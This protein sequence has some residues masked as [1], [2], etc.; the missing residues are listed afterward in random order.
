MLKRF[1]LLPCVVCCVQLAACTER[2]QVVF[3]EQGHRSKLVGPAIE[4]FDR[5]LRG[6]SLAPELHN[7]PLA[8]RLARYAREDGLEL[9]SVPDPAYRLRRDLVVPTPDGRLLFPG[10][11]ANVSE[12]EHAQFALYSRLLSL[13][14]PTGLGTGLTTPFSAAY[15]TSAPEKLAR[16]WV[17]QDPTLSQA[18]AMKELYVQGG[19]VVYARTTDSSRPPYAIVSHNALYQ[20]A[21]VLRNNHAFSDEELAKAEKSLAEGDAPASSA[22][23]RRIL[24]NEVPVPYVFLPLE[25][26]T[27]EQRTSRYFAELEATRRRLADELGLPIEYVVVVPAAFFHV[28]MFVRPIEPGVVLVASQEGVDAGAY[29]VYVATA[30]EETTRILRD[31]G[32]EVHRPRAARYSA[33]DQINYVDV[34]FLNGIAFTT[35]SACGSGKRRVYY[36]TEAPRGQS[37]LEEEFSQFMREHFN[38]EVKFLPPYNNV[39]YGFRRTALE[40]EVEP[41][42][43]S[44]EPLAPSAP[45]RTVN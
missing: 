6:I 2:S 22:D 11:I 13:Q 25:N 15:L 5:T 41:L 28:D 42:A 37:D 40:L 21:F 38:A 32:F 24:G 43:P 33:T 36:A 35:Q 1:L 20:S 16:G 45:S 19:D 17:S 3:E 34:A 31:L 7:I 23:T 39:S 30:L 26:E 4:D 14:A 10:V 18:V 44:D 9:P 29:Q 12:M 27:E 8:T